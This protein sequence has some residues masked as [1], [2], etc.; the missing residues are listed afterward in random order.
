MVRKRLYP[1]DILITG[2]TA[3]LTLLILVFGRPLSMYYNELLMNLGI[4]VLVLAV[5]RFL[6]IPTSRTAML[7]RLL[8]PALLFTFFYEQTGG[9][10]KLIFP[11]F[12]DYQLVAFEKSI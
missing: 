4:V 7:F 8:Y 10:M 1:F 6:H 11:E 2:Y 9:L 3:L 5:I 12:L